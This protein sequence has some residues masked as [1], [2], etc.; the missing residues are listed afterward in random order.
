M[1]LGE[2]GT[3][4]VS[5]WEDIL[6]AVPTGRMMGVDSVSGLHFAGEGLLLAD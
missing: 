3:L 1:A 6:D 2:P 5:Y 4:L